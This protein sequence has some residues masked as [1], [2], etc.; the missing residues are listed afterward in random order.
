MKISRNNIIEDIK[1]RRVIYNYIK[2]FPGSHLREI[3]KNLDLSLSV[4]RY[5]I[6]YMEK[7]GLI[8]SEKDRYYKR[9]FRANKLDKKQRIIALILRQKKFREIILFLLQYPNS[10]HSEISYHLNLPLSTLTKY[11]EYL[12]KNKIVE[13]RKEGR[14]KK[15][16]VIK[17]E[18][19]IKFLI[20]YRESF[21]DRMVDNIL[22]IYFER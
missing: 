17:E 14:I 8:L 22:E 21:S 10:K 16:K 13:E 7:K 19:I 15:Y 4:V 11:M 20:T 1:N 2:N 5:H 9:F 12:I 3:S 18:N 6:H